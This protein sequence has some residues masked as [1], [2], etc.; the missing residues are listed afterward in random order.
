[1]DANSAQTWFVAGTVPLMVGGGLHA[2]A[3][4]IDTL[5]PTYFTP[6][7]SS[8]KA[9]LEG[10]T[11]RLLRMARSPGERSM[12]RIWLGINIGFGL[13]VFTV[14]FTWLV[15][16]THDFGLVDRIG[17]IQPLSIAFSAVFLV[18]ALRFWFYGPVLIT[19]SATVCF[20]VAAVL[21]A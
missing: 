17:A 16:A 11:I 13:A 14:G 15:I 18:V 12:W 7:S 21:A 10:T 19:G 4:V 5:R 6:V 1:M 2:I 20:S 8:V 9:E 3:S